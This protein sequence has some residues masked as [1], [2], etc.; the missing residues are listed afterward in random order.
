MPWSVL[1]YVPILGLVRSPGRFAVLATMCLAVLL[2]QALA[3]LGRRY[4]G[5]PPADPAGDAVL[6]AFELVPVPRTL[7]SAGDPGALPDH[8]PRS[9][10]ADP[11]AGAAGRRPRR[12]QLDRQL[13]GAHAVLPERARQGDHRRLPVARLGAAAAGCAAHA[14]PER[15]RR[16]QRRPG[17]HA[18][19]GRRRARTRRRVPAPI[20]PGLRGGRRD[21]RVTGRWSA[22]PSI[23]SGSPSCRARARCRF[24]CRECRRH[25]TAEAEQADHVREHL[26]RVHQV[27]PGPHDVD[28]S[29]SR[30]TGS[31]GNRSSDTARHAAARG[32]TRGTA[33]RSRPSRSASCSR[34]GT[35]RTRPPSR[36]SRA[37]PRRRRAPRPPCSSAPDCQAPVSSITSALNR[38]RHERHDEDL[39]HARAVPAAPARGC[40]AVP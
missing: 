8:R 14:R 15:A 30:R 32:G 4:P 27:A 19:A 33:R 9:A 6:L 39:H 37:S 7:Y 28:A 17:A 36:R 38:R 24:T 29:P 26:Q 35:R 21:A 20:A 1:R 2:A 10:A 16:A 11:R 34:R 3:H 5:A 31:A 22:S 18:G 13:L 12:H 25:Q 23:C 40:A